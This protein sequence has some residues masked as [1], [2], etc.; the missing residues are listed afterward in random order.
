MCNADVPTAEIVDAPIRLPVAGAGALVSNADVPTAVLM[1]GGTRLS[2]A[3]VAA[4]AAPN[5]GLA[6]ALAAAD[7]E[8][9]AAVDDVSNK[10]GVTLDGAA[11]D[12]PDVARPAD[13]P[14]KLDPPV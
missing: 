3:A 12:A 7:D 5:N 9:V 6:S 1:D 4:P 8:A 14:N 13:V 2:V 11:V 10:D